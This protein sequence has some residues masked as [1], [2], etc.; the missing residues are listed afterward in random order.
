M[1][2]DATIAGFTIMEIWLDVA[3]DPET[4]V[5]EEVITTETTSPFNGA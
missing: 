5:T 4:Q 2:T 3:G 1:E